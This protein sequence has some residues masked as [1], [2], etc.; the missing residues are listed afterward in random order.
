MAFSDELRT[1][2]ADVWEGQHAHPFVRGIAEGTLDIERFRFWV[3]QDYLVLI[4]Y[5]R[6]LALGAARAP[7]PATMR[8]FAELAQSTPVDEMELHR[9]YAA[10][11]G[12]GLRDLEA[13][14]MAPTTRTHADFLVRIA[15][16]GDRAGPTRT[17]A[18]ASSTAA[19]RCQAQQTG[20]PYRSRSTARDGRRPAPAPS[21]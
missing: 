11:F 17:S 1:A 20:W 9:S 14:P 12:I 7:E 18:A 16:Q 4:E 2:S 13:E 19:G 21:L 6:M 5:A 8:R 15:V 3:R 10:E